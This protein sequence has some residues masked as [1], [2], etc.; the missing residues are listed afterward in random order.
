MLSYV[1]PAIGAVLLFV[2]PAGAKDCPTQDLGWEAREAAVGKAP[3]CREAL[4]VAEACAF[5]ASGD[6]GLT[7]IVIEKCEAG[8]LPRLS[9]AQRSAYDGGMKRCDR[10]Y[11]REQGTMYR[12]MEAFCRA[13][14]ARDTAAKFATAPRR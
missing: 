6:T 9:K 1:I 8:F 10:K 12:S 3:T 11:R 2:L 7:G 14:H 5:G 13:K 4:A